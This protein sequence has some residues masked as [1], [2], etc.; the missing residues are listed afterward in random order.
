MLTC[1]NFLLEAMLGSHGPRLQDGA[2][3]TDTTIEQLIMHSH[4]QPQEHT[5][6]KFINEIIKGIVNNRCTEYPNPIDIEGLRVQER[7]RFL[8]NQE[9]R[10]EKSDTTLEKKNRY[11]GEL[12]K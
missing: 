2:K 1:I 9:R 10:V 7:D 5:K 12:E 3:C 11:I 6:T 8:R 4:S